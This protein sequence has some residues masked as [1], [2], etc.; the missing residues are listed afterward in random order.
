MLFLD[1]SSLSLTSCQIQ[2]L[3]HPRVPNSAL[4]RYFA[5]WILPRQCYGSSVIVCGVDS[6]QI[7][8]WCPAFTPERL[9]H[10][11]LGAWIEKCNCQG[12]SN[13]YD[14]NCGKVGNTNG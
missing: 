12:F 5:P 11:P 4:L 1:S 3:I 13:H 10:V 14:V 2:G 6:R 9:I 8:H 7:T